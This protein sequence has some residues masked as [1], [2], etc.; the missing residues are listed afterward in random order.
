MP[1][2]TVGVLGLEL[3]LYKGA[4]TL[5]GGVAVWFLLQFVN[6]LSSDI[7]KLESEVAR[8]KTR[9]LLMKAALESHGIIVPSPKEGDKQ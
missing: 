9:Q 5:I 6:G 3:N 2:Q 7:N 8:L 4:V 1:R